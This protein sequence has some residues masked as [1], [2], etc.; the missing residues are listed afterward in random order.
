MRFLT[1][2][3]ILGRVRDVVSG[4]KESVKVASAW[5]K[6]KNFEE[7]L[8]LLEGKGIELEVILRSSELQD[9]IITD[10][11]VFRR[12]RELGGKVY[13]CRRL[14]AKFVVADDERAVVGS[15]NFTDAG[16]SDMSYGNI[17]AGVLLED[18]KDVKEVVEYFRRVKEEHSV[19]FGEDLVGFVLNPVT[20]ESFEFLSLV[21]D[22]P[23]KS[24]VEVQDGDQTVLA[25]VTTLYAYDMS[26][27]ANPFT[28]QE[29]GVFAPL[30]DFKKI[31]SASSD[32]DWRKSALFA[33]TGQKGEV[34]I[35]TADVVG[36]IRDES[37]DSLKSPFPVGKPV[38]RASGSTLRGVLKRNFSGKEMGRPVR[39]GVLRDTDIEALIDGEEVT[40][41]HM[42]II[43]TTGSGKSYFATRFLERLASSY[44]DI[45]IF[46]FDPH[47]EY[48]EPLKETLGEEAVEHIPLEDTLFPIYPDELAELVVEAGYSNLVRGNSNLARNNMSKLS[49][50]IKPSLRL[51]ALRHRNLKEVICDIDAEEEVKE[52][53]LNH[54]STIYGEGMISNQSSIYLRLMDAL[55][56]QSKTVVIDFS[57]ITDP[58]T[59]V[60][61]AGLLMQELFLMAREDRRDRLILLEEA[62]NFA[63]EKSFGDVSGGKDNLSLTMARKIASEGR[64]FN[65]GM[66]TITQRPAQVSKYVLSQMNTQAMFRTINSADL[67]AISSLVEY[68]GEEVIRTL[69]ALTTGTGVISGIGVPFPLVI[70]VK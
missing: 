57:R 19:E 42:L 1:S 23:V 49:K 44:E 8:S 4:A 11:R 40:R 35:A 3:E 50:A 53:I 9:M 31:F 60:N 26:F 6:G 7:L 33:Y 48:A 64:K 67:D 69:P 36:T 25:R 20:H 45:H 54:L 62:H 16:L 58:N 46:V 10:E 22:L 65:L 61:I 39:A 30:E 34:W 51:T 18:P 59:R 52:E 38:Y 21:K 68:A 55:N 37:I 41:K 2:D 66:I 43:G 17:E 24:F 47:G 27:F 5:I 29:S 32:Q 13:L 56:S 70:E 12:I 63:P 14:H 15:A 28:S